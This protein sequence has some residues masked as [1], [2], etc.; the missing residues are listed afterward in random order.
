MTDFMTSAVG[1]LRA[2]LGPGPTA[3]AAAPEDSSR[4]D[5]E[6]QEEEEDSEA[7]EVAE[8]AASDPAAPAA[9]VEAGKPLAQV[10]VLQFS[11]D[12]RVEVAPTDLD[13]DSFADAMAAM[14]GA[15]SPPALRMPWGRCIDAWSQP[16]E[17]DERRL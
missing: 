11:N 16:P 6:P 1:T 14:V 9:G 4:E 7:E 2:L 10:A 17:A 15:P 5:S 12:V 13:P 3:A 8:G